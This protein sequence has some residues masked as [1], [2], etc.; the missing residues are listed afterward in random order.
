MGT[1]TTFDAMIDAMDAREWPHYHLWSWNMYIVD[2]TGNAIQVQSEWGEEP[3]YAF[4]AEGD[5]LQNLCCQGN[6]SVSTAPGCLTA[7]QEACPGLERMNST[8]MD[9]A[10]WAGGMLDA[11]GCVNADIAEYCIDTEY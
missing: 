4:L 11:A 9:C 2:P 6:C 10:H 3:D 7:L 8:C 1:R 5:A